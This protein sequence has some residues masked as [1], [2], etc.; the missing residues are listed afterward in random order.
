ML[1]ALG[2]GVVLGRRSLAASQV[3]LSSTAPASAAEEEPQED[4]VALARAQVAAVRKRL[5]Q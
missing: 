2:S 5:S 4:V 3:A 1:I